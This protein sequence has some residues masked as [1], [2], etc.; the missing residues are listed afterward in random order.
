MHRGCRVLARN[1]HAPARAR[2]EIRRQTLQIGRRVLRPRGT[3]RLPAATD[4]CRQRR[5]KCCHFARLHCQAMLRLKSRRRRP[6]LDH[7]QPVHLLRAVELALLRVVAR[8]LV[9]AR[10]LRAAQEIR[11]QRNNHIG[12]IQLVLRVDIIAKRLLRR[13][14]MIVAIHRVVLHQLRL[15]IILLRLLP[16]RRQ[17]RRGHGRRQEIQSLPGALFLRQ[18]VRDTAARNAAHVRES[19]RYMIFCERSGSYMSSSVACVI[20]S[21]AAL[22]HT[23]AL[24]CRRP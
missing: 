11:I 17:R 12:L 16:L 1:H 2:L 22:S 20:G 3:S 13:G 15:R 19:P 24:D 4:C 5:G 10:E 7:V 6:A 14:V 8:Q 23:D 9:E 21:D 18:H